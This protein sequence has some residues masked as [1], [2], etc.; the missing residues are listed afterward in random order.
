MKKEIKLTGIVEAIP[1][2][3]YMCESCHT[4]FRIGENL[5]DNTMVIVTPC[6]CYHCD[7][8]DADNTMKIHNDSKERN[9][10][11]FEDIA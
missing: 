5:I 2:L 1:E 8:E 4:T 10:F 3:K 9:E 6:N 11:E 7:N